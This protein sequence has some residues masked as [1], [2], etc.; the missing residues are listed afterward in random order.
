MPSNKQTASLAVKD[1]ASDYAA[2]KSRIEI[3]IRKGRERAKAAVEAEKVRTAWEVGR[4]IEVDILK[5]EGRAAYGKQV[6]KKLSADIGVSDTELK[7]MVELARAY[8]IGPPTGQLSWGHHRELLA[9]NDAA[10]RKQLTDQAIESH[11]SVLE[12]R[13]EIRKLTGRRKSRSQ[14]EIS[15][16]F[17]P[18]RGVL[19]TYRMDKRDYVDLGFS[20]FFQPD[21]R[22]LIGFKEGDILDLEKGKL[23]TLGKGKP[24]DLYSPGRD[25]KISPGSA[26]AVEPGYTYQASVERVI[27]GDTLWVWIEL[28]FKIATRQKLRLR[29]LDC[30]ELRTAKGQKA[31]R[32][33][34]EL[35][36]QSKS[37]VV[38]TT[39][40]DKFS[41]YLTDL[42]LTLPTGAKMCLNKYLL[43]HRLA[44]PYDAVTPEDW[45][46]E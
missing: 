35:L 43:D 27:D 5:H 1:A 36:K 20:L 23:V 12:L 41:R 44:R 45:D 28:G 31:R 4:E 25:V 37:I 13:S 21:L 26:R 9:V 6:I 40:P 42:F 32:A 16:R 10:T 3:L 15:F 14:K 30:P 7:Y 33:V 38:T 46:A 39:K 34:E 24:E 18:K 29:G 11:W 2:L 17:L 8:R 19:N 22:D